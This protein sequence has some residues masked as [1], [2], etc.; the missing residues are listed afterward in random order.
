L[1][2]LSIFGTSNDEGKS[3]IAFALAYILHKRGYNVAPFK[4]QSTSKNSQVSD[5]GGE[6]AIPQFFAAE[7]IGIK[8]SY[9]MNPV[10]LKVESPTKTDL[11]IH[12]KSS[13][14]KDIWSCYKD[15]QM[16]KPFVKEAFVKLSKK[17]ECIVAE[18]AGNPVEQSFMKRDLSNIYIAEEFKTKIILVT[19]VEDGTLF[20]SVYGVYK[21]LPKKLRDNVI[22]VIVDKFQSDIAEFD[23]GVQIIEQLF[24]M[25]VLGVVPH[26]ELTLGFDAIESMLASPQDTK[27]SIITVG[28]IQL[29][30]IS[31]ITEFEPHLADKE[32][33]LRFITSLHEASLCDLLILPGSKMVVE[34]LDWLI[35]NGIKNIL[36]SKEQ[37]LVAISGGYEMLHTLI[38]DPNNIESKQ[39]KTQGLGRI[40]GEVRFGKKTI[41]KKGLYAIFGCKIEGY[42]LHNAITKELAIKKKN[43]HATLVHG[44]FDNNR[45]RTKLFEDINKAYKGY[46]FQAYKQ[47][48]IDEFA[49]HIEK[50]V[51]IDVIEKELQ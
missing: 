25:R 44:I 24:G 11:I 20:S 29:P 12:G 22:G 38:L 7:A 10:L 46:D 42:E 27:E 40:E 32:I 26:K 33:E 5:D 43:L 15:T 2:S 17:Y 9:L 4:A 37:K 34:D 41:S 8:S 1:K 35:E 47:K 50:S 39:K 23:E 3:S 18:G 49:S 6:M 14:K 31:N 51:T 19:S 13:G 30:N 28:V 45:F 48:I 21:L 16:L 36:T